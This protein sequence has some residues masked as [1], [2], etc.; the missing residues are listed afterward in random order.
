MADKK[1]IQG[2]IK[3]PAALHKTLGVPEGEKIPEKK[4]QKALHSS[5]ETTK[6]RAQLAETL[7]HMHHRHHDKSRG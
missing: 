6:K 4:M 7:G 3:H 5:N 1:W 2:A